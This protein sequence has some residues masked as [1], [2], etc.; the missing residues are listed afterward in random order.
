MP[1]SAAEVAAR[2][3]AHGGTRSIGLRLAPRPVW[4]LVAG[5]L[6][7]ALLG[8]LVVGSMQRHAVP[9]GTAYEAVFLHLDVVGETPVVVAV[10]VDAAGHEREI[11][12]VSDTWIAYSVETGAP[13][14]QFLAPTG[15][16][17]PG[18]LLAIPKSVDGW[19][20]H[21]EIVDLKHPQ[22]PPIVVPG[23]E[24]DIEQIQFSPYF[25]SD[26]RPSVFWGPGERVAIPWYLRSDTLDWHLSF[27]DGRTGSTAAVDVPETVQVLPQWATD[28]SG[29]FV[30]TDTERRQL[31]RPDG[32]VVGVVSEV[33]QDACRQRDE[34]GAQII[35]ADGRMRWSN[36]DG[37]DRP[38]P[39]G[40]VTMACYAPDD[41]MVV[42]DLA[43][44]DAPGAATASERKG[45][46]IDS[47]TGMTYDT[48][49]SFA[50]WM[51]V[52]AP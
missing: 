43:I 26:M 41:S 1:P 27:V 49:G 47:N 4:I 19:L 21:W 48:K 10:G 33:S 35:V 20:V 23:I 44:G 24:Q 32:T 17:S 15:A 40:D 28:G 14:R 22:A 37:S 13:Q 6:V 42:Y 30:I 12:R 45:G 31:L 29:V 5:L 34:S 2:I 9:L 46:L 25:S 39:S 7:A 36:A 16:V 18:G 50:G 8:A 52:E 38:A 3:S 51:A 11:A